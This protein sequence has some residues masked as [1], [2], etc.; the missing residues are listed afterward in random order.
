M[1]RI[2]DTE[3]FLNIICDAPRLNGL[4]VYLMSSY[5]NF[6]AFS[7]VLENLACDVIEILCEF[8][9]L[10]CHFLRYYF[11]DFSDGRFPFEAVQTLCQGLYYYYSDDILDLKDT[12]F[13]KEG[14]M[15]D[16]YEFWIAFLQCIPIPQ[17][18]EWLSFEG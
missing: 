10:R 11:S 5:S 3:K 18:L 17:D 13:M 12:G 15:L 9:E 8:G 6:V 14:E 16:C 4:H 2:F 7:N 1:R